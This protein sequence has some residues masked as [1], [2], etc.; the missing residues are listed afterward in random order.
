M[1]ISA[2][3]TMLS[4]IGLLCLAGSHAQENCT[5]T[6]KLIDSATGRELSGL[7]SVADADGNRVA[8]RELLSRGLG[9]DETLPIGR[10]S[11]LAKSTTL[12]LPK[13]KLIIAALSGLET[14]QNQ[15]TIDLTTQDRA[16][17][18]LLLK[19]FY[20]ASLRGYRSANTHLHLQK[21]SRAE[22]D[23]YLLEV[24]QADGL[25]LLFLSYLER[26]GADREYTSNRYTDGDLAS[27]TKIS[28]VTFGNGEEHRHNFT[29]FGEGY[30]H[31]MLLN[32]QK[33]IQPVSIGQGIMKRGTDGIPLQRGIDTARRDDATIIWCHNSWGREAFPNFLTGRVNAQNIFD[34]GPHGSYKDSFYRYLNAGLQVP[35]STGTDWF[36]YDFSRAYAEMTGEVSVKS[37]LKALAAGRTYIT[38]G[39]LLEFSADGKKIG[40]TIELE[41]PGKTEV[42]ARAVGRVDFGRIELVR[43]G[44]VVARSPSRRVGRHYEADLSMAVEQPGPGWL[45]LRT[46]PPPVKDDPLLQQPVSKNEFGHDLFA[47]TS[48]IYVEVGGRSHFD[49]SVAS[50]WLAAMKNNHDF[51]AEKANF[52][53]DQERQRVLDVY[54]D[55][56]AEMTKKL[57]SNASR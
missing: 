17:V 45:A 8:V 26:A 39:P 15:I 22:C 19:R 31:V 27:L 47:H 33:L 37:W 21:I 18:T 35:F 34:G 9:L 24:P 50:R 56:I 11:V 44:R 57:K 51:I 53:D 10:W 52:S 5:V 38:N 41:A 43:N 3:M 42:K 16:N 29:G 25:D 49:P 30:G 55:G 48:A 28:G 13:K 40:E 46:P 1:R 32:I 7:V 36:M 6:L 54:R 20:D 2:A 23:R 4:M 14:E 12:Q